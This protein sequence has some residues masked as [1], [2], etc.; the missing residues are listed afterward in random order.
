MIGL[1]ERDIQD[2]FTLKKAFKFDVLRKI[3]N[4]IALTL[5]KK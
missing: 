2:H 1:Q 3:E 5:M 4:L